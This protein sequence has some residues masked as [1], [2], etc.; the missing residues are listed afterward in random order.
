MLYE[1]SPGFQGWYMR[2]FQLQQHVQIFNR[3]MLSVE[4]NV[5]QMPVPVGVD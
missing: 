1:T 2:L 3:L 5:Q 4:Q